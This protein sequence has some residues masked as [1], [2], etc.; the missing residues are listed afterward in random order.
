MGENQIVRVPCRRGTVGIASASR[1]EDHGFKSPPG[2]SFWAFI[3][4]G[5]AVKAGEA[6][7]L[8]VSEIKQT[9]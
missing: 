1:T 3:H 7:S 2:F 6:L 9:I 4:R 5:V 8:R